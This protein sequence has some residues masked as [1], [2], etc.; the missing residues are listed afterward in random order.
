MARDGLQSDLQLYLRQINEVPL[1]TAEQERELGWRIINDNDHAAKD[2]M[3][4]ANLRLVVSISKNYA[5]RGLSLADLI[6]EGN[7]GLIRAVEGFDPAQGARFSTYASWWIKQA[8]KRTLINAS[9]PIH[10][11]AYMVELIARWKDSMRRLHE[12]FGRQPTNSELA[13]EME[14][15]V[16]KLA[17]IRRAMKALNSSSQAP[18]GDD[19]E[20][21]DFA[22]LFPD[23]RHE[24]PEANIAQKEE[25][26][27]IL[28]LIDAI[29]ERD[30]RVLK[31]RF[32]LEGKEPLTLKQIGEEVGLTRERV[33]QIEMEALKKL[34]MQLSDD[35]PSRFFKDA[36]CSNG[37]GNGN[38]NGHRRG[39]NRAGGNRNKNQ[40]ETAEAHHNGFGPMPHLADADTEPDQNTPRAKAG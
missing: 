10:I 13:A 37:N 17:I 29:D 4:K 15:P 34:A 23:F 36:A 6:E 24:Q 1:L 9:Q 39:K 18:M 35:R 3:V 33:R 12:Q 28:K 20:P 26:Q 5:H 38:G 8:I 40:F 27:T 11:P 14:L 32:G 7:I 30:A 21:L 25:F 19:G 2:Q 31:L 16:K 22:D